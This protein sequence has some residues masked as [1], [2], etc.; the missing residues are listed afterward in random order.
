MATIYE[1][2]KEAG[3]SPSTVA[4]ALRGSGYCSLKNREKIQAIA[5]RMGYAPNHAAR[6]LKSKRSQKVLFC[7][8]D[9]YNPFYFR[10]IK[11]ATEVLEKHDYFPILCHTRADPKLELRMLS[12][13]QQGYG[14]GMIF[15]SFDFNPHN[16]AAVN[17]SGCPVVLNNN[18]QSP[19][20]QD[21]FDCVYVDTYDGVRMAAQHF[22]DRGVR[23]IGY[24]GG[25][26][27]TQTGR[28]RFSGFLRALQD[29]NLTPDQRWFKV[30][31]FSMES[32]HQAMEELVAQGPLPDALVVANDLMAIGAMQVCRDKGISVPGELCLIGMDNSDLAR[33][34][35]LSSIHMCEE[36]I[37]RNA[38]ELLMQRIEDYGLQKR[39]VRLQP[40]LV[41]RGSSE[42]DPTPSPS[43]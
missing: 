14:D 2:A 29:A 10:M 4:R 34:L 39:T 3:V 26:P 16:V 25:R 21:R 9:I 38:A 28:E 23:R 35:G 43:K 41:L 33:M 13:L 19:E 32:G 15:V 30:G 31:D 36:E 42:A 17:A 5:R 37:G 6:S 22:L 24:I 12:M 7:I 1:I 18:Y 8:P 27:S 20:G 40:Q 11:G